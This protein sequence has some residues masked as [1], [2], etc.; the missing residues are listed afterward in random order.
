MKLAQLV[1][2]SHSAVELLVLHDHEC[3]PRCYVPKALDECTEAADTAQLAIF[4][5]DDNEFNITEEL[6]SLVLL[7]D[8]N[9][10]VDWYEAVKATFSL[11]IDTMSGIVTVGASAMV[12]KKEGQ[13]TV[14][15]NDAKKMECC[16]DNGKGFPRHRLSP[17]NNIPTS[18]L[19]LPPPYDHV[20]LT[21]VA[22]ISEIRTFVG[23]PGRAERKDNRVTPTSLS[24]FRPMGSW[25]SGVNSVDSPSLHFT[26]GIG[27]PTATHVKLTSPPTVT[28]S[29]GR[30]GI[31]NCGGTLRTKMKIIIIDL[32]TLL[33]HLHILTAF[34]NGDILQTSNTDSFTKNSWDTN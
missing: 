29:T 33:V 22:V 25:S 3:M 26:K 13:T 32:P 27:E 2:L 21:V 30:G 16:N 11:T 14:I 17:S 24:T 12:R 18:L 5:Q 19:S 9:R 34:L 10:S 7:K 8:T 28:S 20:N 31:E 23:G 4:I 1:P 15:E 6:A